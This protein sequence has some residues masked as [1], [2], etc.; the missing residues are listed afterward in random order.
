MRWKRMFEADS[1]VFVKSRP[2][3]RIL[4]YNSRLIV[5]HKHYSF[6]ISA[7][8]R[9]EMMLSACLETFLF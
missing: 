5:T 2:H 9:A 3:I 4:F 8:Q 6:H 7:K 1:S